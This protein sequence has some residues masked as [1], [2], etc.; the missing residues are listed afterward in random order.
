MMTFMCLAKIFE[1]DFVA[2]TLSICA[3]IL[4]FVG[5]FFIFAWSQHDCFCWTEFIMPRDPVSLFLY[6]VDDWWNIY[7]RP[8]SLDE[9]SIKMKL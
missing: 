7:Y 1:I 3:P 4:I 2:Y 5:V 9:I 8:A 6:I